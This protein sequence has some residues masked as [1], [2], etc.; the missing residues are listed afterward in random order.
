[1]ASD[2]DIVTVD[3]TQ[4]PPF[5]YDGAL[6]PTQIPGDPEIWGG[7]VHAALESGP[8]ALFTFTGSQ[9]SV[10]GR[11]VPLKNGADPPLSLYSVGSIHLQAFIP[12]P[13]SS[14]V[15]NVAFFNSSVMPYGQYTLIINVT[16]ASADAPF[17]LDY[18]R[19]NI[20]HPS[21]PTAASTSASVISSSSTAIPISTS[22]APIVRASSSPPVGPIVGGV[23]GG[24]VVVAA[25]VIAFFYYRLRK[26]QMSSS[27]SDSPPPMM[28]PVTPY[29]VS[30]HTASQS[31][32]SEGPSSGMYSPPMRQIGSTYSLGTSASATATETA[33]DY[34]SKLASSKATRSSA[35]GSTYGG[36]SSGLGGFGVHALEVATE[37]VPRYSPGSPS[38][39]SPL[40]SMHDLPNL[41]GR[42]GGQ[43]RGQRREMA[44][45]LGA[46]STVGLSELGMGVGVQADSGMRFQPGLTPSDVAPMLSPGTVSPIRSTPTRSEV[47]RADIPP[48][49]TPD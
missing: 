26:R 21:A 31:R 29:M 48:A 3:D 18:V 1:M 27:P 49:Y 20:T 14:P 5:E 44:S 30:E 36:S 32:F 4:Q 17:Y 40:S 41:G 15:D 8:S 33:R 46:P 35:L 11:V 6:I 22:A 9:V 25:A 2:S 45:L 38:S 23:V 28:P 42:A 10:Y 7:Y 47:A 16:R 37:G 12:N 34:K 39:A 19:Y 13:V 43:T 24:V